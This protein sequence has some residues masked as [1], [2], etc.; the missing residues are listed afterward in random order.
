MLDSP[1]HLYLRRP[2]AEQ[3]DIMDYPA[4]IES[5]NTA[6]AERATALRFFNEDVILEDGKNKTKGREEVIKLLEAAHD[7][8]SEALHIRSWAQT[9]NT[10]LAELD[11]HFV[12]REDAPGHFFYPFKKGEKVRFRFMAAYTLAGER[13]S[14]MRITYW[15]SPVSDE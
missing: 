5:Y 13:F 15:P 8:I 1:V 9:G 14:H 10:I 12:S 2:G 6:N 4:Y 7:G 3:A 11:G